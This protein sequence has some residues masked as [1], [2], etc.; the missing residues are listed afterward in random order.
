MGFLRRPQNLT[1]SSSY[2]W[3]ERRVLCAQQRTCQKG[4]VDED[5][6]KQM[7]NFKRYISPRDHETSFSYFC[8]RALLR[9]SAIE[10]V[11]KTEIFVNIT[12]NFLKKERRIRKMNRQSSFWKIKMQYFKVDFYS[13]NKKLIRQITL[14]F[15][16]P[17]CFHEFLST[18]Y[19]L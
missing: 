15:N 4:T 7:W 16:F 10:S 1:K 8:G 13:V 2:F 11:L 9:L 14:S 3:L 5:F 6:S 17:P 19:S 18:Y 12:K